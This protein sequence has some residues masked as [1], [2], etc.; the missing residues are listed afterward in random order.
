MNP[1]PKLLALPV[2]KN[3]GNTL[4]RARAIAKRER[5]RVVV[6]KDYTTSAGALRQKPLLYVSPQGDVEE[7]LA[8]TLR[9]RVAEL[10]VEQIL[11]D[12]STQSPAARLLETWMRI[13]ELRAERKAHREAA[14]A[15]A[16]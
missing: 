4:M 7:V 1:Q 6:V 9:V 12:G 13:V 11:R 2:G 14:R 15:K 3:L 16:A 10:A 5:T 8:P